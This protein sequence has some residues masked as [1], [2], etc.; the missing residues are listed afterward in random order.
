LREV[1]PDEAGFTLIE[2]L[3]ASA[4]G[5]VLM[6]AVA[7]LVISAVRD[8]PAISRKAADVQ[9]S[10][11]VMER[12]TRELREGVVVDKASASS[13]SFQ[14]YVRHATCGSATALASATPAIKCEVTF[15]C[16]ASAC[17]RLETAPGVFT[18][19]PVTIVSGLA[20][21]STVFTYS[22][23]TGATTYVGIT[24]NIAPPKAGSPG[25]TVSDGASLR[26][27][28]LAN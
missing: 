10:R 9:T 16:S 8:Q 17:T 27:A 15:T 2:L 28:T 5:V 24:L 1:G 11:F 23:S 3:V 20:N 18:G 19:T 4:M 25:T 7:S 26:N 12:L 13:V 22:P 21:G 6:G 14:T